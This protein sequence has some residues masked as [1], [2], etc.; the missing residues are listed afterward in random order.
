MIRCI[1]AIIYVIVFLVLGIFLN[2]PVA[3]VRK[4]DPDRALRVSNR[5]IRAAFACLNFICGVR[6]R[7]SGRENLPDEPV[8]FAGNHRSYFDIIT[9]HVALNRPLGYVAKKEF[10]KVPL[11]SGWMKN[12][13]CIFLDRNDMKEAMKA[14]IQGINILKH[15]TCSLYI[16]PEGTRG[17]ADEMKPFHKGSFKLAQKSGRKIVP[18]AVWNT[19]NVFENNPALWKVIGRKVYIKIGKP[20]DY[21]ELEDDQKKHIDVYVQ[22]QVA[23][24]IK[25]IRTENNI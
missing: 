6:I 4:K 18:V 8:L 2:I 22:N 19:D 17:H 20:V 9:T 5:I 14:I 1:I 10:L 23:D 12:I 11:F 16:F 21:S 25:A 13:G 24:L 7:V 15:G 3:I